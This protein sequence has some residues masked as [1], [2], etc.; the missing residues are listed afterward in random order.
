MGLMELDIG[1]GSKPFQEPLLI[2]YV[3]G[4]GNGIVTVNGDPAQKRILIFQ[5]ANEM[6]FLKQTWSQADGS[7]LIGNLNINSIY[8]VIAVD[9]RQKYEP[10]AWDWIKPAINND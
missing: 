7:Y 4:T 10:V 9:D 2:G 6:V 1:F 8:M 3:A 5:R